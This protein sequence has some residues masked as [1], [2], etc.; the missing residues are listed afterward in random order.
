MVVVVV[1]VVNFVFFFPLFLGGCFQ[2]MVFNGLDNGL[3]VFLFVFIVL[4]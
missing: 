2:C 4:S 3:L 1:V